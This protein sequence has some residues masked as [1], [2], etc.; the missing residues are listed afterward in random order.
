MKPYVDFELVEHK[1]KT[2]V[3]EV[4]SKSS[5]DVLGRI[6]WY[7]PWRQYVFESVSETIWSRGCLKEI[8]EFVEKLMQERKRGT[9][10]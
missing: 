3:Y 10:K 4:F 6:F 2:D 5:L 7:G 1:P 9:V 8:M